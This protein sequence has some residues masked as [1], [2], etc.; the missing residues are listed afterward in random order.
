M[1][2]RRG[3]VEQFRGGVLSASRGG[4]GGA[5]AAATA[6]LRRERALLCHLDPRRSATVATCCSTSHS[7]CDASP[8]A[9]DV[10]AVEAAAGVDAVLL[11]HHVDALER[12]G[13]TVSSR[14]Y[15][16]A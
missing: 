4:G 6:A 5:A 8:A 11:A 13:V 15:C 3:E 2:L 7:Y 12:D 1:Q 16:S 10:A 14:E 9:Q